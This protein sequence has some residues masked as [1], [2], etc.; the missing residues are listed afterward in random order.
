MFEKLKSL[1]IVENTTKSD[2]NPLPQT[3]VPQQSVPQQNVVQQNNPSPQIQNNGALVEPKFTEILVRALEE[4]NLQGL[5]YFEFKQ[6]LQ[7]TQSLA[8]DEPTRFRSAYAMGQTMGLTLPKLLETADY[9]MKVLE[10]ED[11]KFMDA[12]KQQG[13]GKNRTMIDE[14][15]AMEKAI[16]DK[17]V[18]IEQMHQEIAALQQQTS[19]MKQSIGE[20]AQRIEATKNSF[21]ATYQ[22][23]RNQIIMDKQ[24]I[25]QYLK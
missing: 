19:T 23:I 8:I 13:E 22:H 25:E 2:S 3:N 1:F 16:A 4:N 9:Y 20:T 5:D 10:R 21:D 15:A 11:Q 14:V 18:L 12:L 7:A 24:K 17:T 6:S